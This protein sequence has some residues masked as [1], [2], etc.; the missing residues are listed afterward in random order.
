M[1]AERINYQVAGLNSHGNM[2]IVNKYKKQERMQHTI[3]SNYV[4]EQQM[5]G[6]ELK[7][8]LSEFPNNAH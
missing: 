1:C 2:R 4:H 6:S 3:Y 8:V 5:G 7:M